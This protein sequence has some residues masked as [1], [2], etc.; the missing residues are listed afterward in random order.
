[1]GGNFA[2]ATPDTVATEEA[3]RSCALTVHVSTKLNRSHLVHGERALILPC[4]GRSELDV[5]VSGP[6]RVTVEDSMS[7]VH[8]SQGTLKPASEHLLSEP[9]IVAGVAEATLGLSTISWGNLVDNYD[10]I[11][12]VISRVIPGF[13]N[14]NERIDSPSGFYLG[15]S[16]AERTWETESGKAVLSA[17]PIPDLGLAPGLLRLMTLRSHDQY[18]TTVYSDDDR[19]RGI[20]GERRVILCHPEDLKERGITPGET[21]NLVSVYEDGER[22]CDAFRTV[23]YD[24]P[25]GCAAGYFPEMNPLVSLRS[26][27][28]TSGTPTSKW[29]PVRLERL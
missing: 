16:A 24:I 20:R 23:S 8:A 5:Q 1:M 22:R 27:A 3:L 17:H 9:A 18:N 25:R 15:N 13:E 11:R 6:Q 19:Y 21:V 7:V 2:A 4:L 14:Y 26:V 28:T 29:I 12:D 10:R